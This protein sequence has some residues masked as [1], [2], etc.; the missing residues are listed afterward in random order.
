M[1]LHE[2][3]GLAASA[4]ASVGLYTSFEDIDA[5]VRQPQAGRGDAAMMEGAAMDTA[6]ERAQAI[7]ADEPEDAGAEGAAGRGRGDSASRIIEV[8]RTVYDP[9]IPV[10]IYEL[11]L[12]YKIDIEDDDRVLVDM[13]LTSPHCPVAETLPGEVEQKVAAVEGVDRLRGQ[14]RLGP[15]L[16]PVDD[17]R[18]G[19]ARA[20]DDLLSWPA[21]ADR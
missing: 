17:D 20:G 14:D 21:H 13:T 11:G 19:P 4:R 12:I 15:A 3:F 8:L 1:P 16:E 2:R 9:E 10:N 6:M 5:F 7:L 18:G